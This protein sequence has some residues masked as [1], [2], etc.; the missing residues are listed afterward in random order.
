MF[1]SSAH[2]I[3]VVG[4]DLCTVRAMESISWCCWSCIGIHLLPIPFHLC[5]FLDAVRLFKIIRRR[6]LD[7]FLLFIA[8]PRSAEIDW[9]YIRCVGWFPLKAKTYDVLSIPDRQIPGKKRDRKG[10]WVTITLS[11]LYVTYD[12]SKRMTL[13]DLQQTAQL[14][15]M[16]DKGDDDY[17][18]SVVED[19][20]QDALAEEMA[21]DFHDLQDSV[22]LGTP[23]LQ[24]IRDLSTKYNLKE[25]AFLVEV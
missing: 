18:H 4:V 14:E 2:D 23:A 24:T 17:G 25:P 9:K 12:P 10:V 16:E 20:S 7:A 19:D 13:N 21:W 11:Q 22:C 15:S 8:Y 5:E 6:A 3:L 1:R